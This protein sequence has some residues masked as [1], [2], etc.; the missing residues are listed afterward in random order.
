MP[1]RRAGTIA[2]TEPVLWRK[3]HKTFEAWNAGSP[4]LIL[5]TLT[6]AFWPQGSPHILDGNFHKIFVVEAVKGCVKTFCPFLALIRRVAI[7]IRE[8]L[9]VLLWVHLKM[10][11]SISPCSK[12]SQ[13]FAF[14]QRQDF[15]VLNFQFLKP[16][17]DGVKGGEPEAKITGFLSSS[18][19]SSVLL[20]G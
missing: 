8:K 7:F 11:R 19:S 13:I 9:E 14:E 3:R 12:I 4:N 6:R 15:G 20:S 1:L 17:G 2:T 18:P 10:E 16:L 5:V